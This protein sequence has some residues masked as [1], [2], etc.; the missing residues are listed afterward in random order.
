MTTVDVIYYGPCY[1]CGEERRLIRV[2]RGGY[3]PDEVAELA[4]YLVGGEPR[5]RDAWY[6]CL[7][8]LADTRTVRCDGCG[9]RTSSPTVVRVYPRHYTGEVDDR[10][11]CPRCEGRGREVEVS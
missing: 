10:I 1:W 4:G 3:S 2:S 6:V 8:C 9:R 7:P 11:L 5:L